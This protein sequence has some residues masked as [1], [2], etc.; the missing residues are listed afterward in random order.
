[1]NSGCLGFGESGGM[2]EGWGD[3]YATAIRMHSEK[4]KDWTMGSWVANSTS[5]IRKYPYSTNMTVD[6]GEW[7]RPSDSPLFLSNCYYKG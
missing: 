7:S 4:N 3:F 2:G 1:M 6:P 5:G